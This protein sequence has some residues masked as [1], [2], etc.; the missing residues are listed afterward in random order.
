MSADDLIKKLQEPSTWRGIAVLVGLVC[1]K[2]KPEDT[3]NFIMGGLAISGLINVIWNE[4]KATE[5]AVAK[6]LA[7]TTEIEGQ[8]GK[9]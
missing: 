8:T 3:A 2:L 4:T 9:E 5:K 1:A 7:N 6:I